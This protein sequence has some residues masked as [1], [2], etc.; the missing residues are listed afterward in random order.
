MKVKKIAALVA[1]AAMLGATV[2]YAS[3]VHW[4]PSEAEMP[5]KDFFVK[6]GQPNVKIV[7]GS[8]GAAQDVVAAADIAVALGT[9]LYNEK[10]VEVT[11]PAVFK[12]LPYTADTIPVYETPDVI[13]VSDE[14]QLETAAANYWYNGA[15]YE[16]Y[17]YFIFS[18]KPNFDYVPSVYDQYWNDYYVPHYDGT[19][20]SWQALWDA[21]DYYL[22][23]GRIEKLIG[24]TEDWMSALDSASPNV[25]VTVTIDRIELVDPDGKSYPTGDE[26]I[27]IPAGNFTY[28][29]S[30]TQWTY[31]WVSGSCCEPGSPAWYIDDPGIQPGDSFT[32]LGEKY[33]AIC[34]Y[35]NYSAGLDIATICP[36]CEAVGAQEYVLLLATDAIG[37]QEGWV[38]V[39]GTLT[40]GPN[41]EYTINVLD[42]NIVGTEKVLVKV[43]DNTGVRPAATIGIPVNQAYSV[44]GDYDGDGDDDLV[45]T[46]HSTFIGVNGNTQARL[47]VYTDL[48]AVNEGD[49][50]PNSEWKVHF[51]GM[52][53]NASASERVRGTG[54]RWYYPNI[55]G[56][57]DNSSGMIDLVE[58]PKAVVA[59]E[60]TNTND[61][62]DEKGAA[63]IEVPLNNPVY[64]LVYTADICSGECKDEDNDEYYGKYT[65]S[66]SAWIEV[67][68][69][70]G[71]LTQ[72]VEVG[73][74]FQ[75][76][77]LTS[78]GEVT[79]V[80]PSKVTSPITMLD[81]EVMAAGLDQV[82]SN[83]ILVGG[84]VVNSV[85]AALAEKLGVPSDYDGW[86][87][88]FGTGADSAVVAYKAECADI[89]GYGVLLV[90]GTDREGT[91]AA[92]EALMDYLS[93]L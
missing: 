50:W 54:D 41:D 52:I 7:V 80:E 58:Y 9:M 78:M 17:P 35:G 69:V 62:P 86:E 4:I 12:E 14:D 77:S 31:K 71:L 36:T 65:Y 51:R 91:L 70:G 81:E 72:E 88:E 40:A 2:G 19:K 93:E 73:D 87:S 83:L 5:A 15:H 92:A 61:L 13:A 6:D 25:K 68:R 44:W 16:E 34:V 74:E 56:G 63:K 3:A 20:E 33:H 30:F 37:G 66:A 27:L 49:L 47:L 29:A 89:G 55:P 75:G 82:G 10:E 85:T 45:I 28:A 46:L 79:T 42:I 8:Q 21:D 64:E 67:N 57:G 23:L 43:V 76:Y 26:K 38:T 24:P 53:Y 84:P 90:A 32:L 39:G 59:I 18:N 60:L 1:G 22:S 48:R 11:G